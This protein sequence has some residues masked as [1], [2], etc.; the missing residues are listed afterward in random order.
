MRRA[1]FLFAVLFLFSAVSFAVTDE[2]HKTYTLSGTPDLKVTTSDAAIRVS[3]W[4][5]NEIE[6]RVTSEGY[7]IGENGLHIIEHQTGNIVEIEV[8]Y[9]HS[10]IHFGWHHSRV[11][12][13]IQMPKNGNTNLRTGDG[14]VRL[15]GLSGKMDISTGD[16]SVEV[17]SVDGVLHAH[18]GDGHI[19]AYGRFDDLALDTGDGRIDATALANSKMNSDWRINTGDGSVSLRVPE[20]L[21][22]N[23]ELHTS[24]GHIDFDLPITTSGRFKSNTINGTMNGGGRMLSVHTG[25]GSIRL[26]RS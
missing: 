9:P 1:S 2:W 23:V 17:D 25:D 20:T 18:T 4:D 15:A 5:R 10:D 19:R 3:T 14:S 12:I 11:E 26:A 13:N 21:A 16:G 22:A 6:A 24:D 7:K 8:R